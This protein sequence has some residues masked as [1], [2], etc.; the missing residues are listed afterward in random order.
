MLCACLLALCVALGAFAALVRPSGAARAGER[1]AFTQR[2]DPTYSIVKGFSLRDPFTGRTFRLAAGLELLFAENNAG[3]HA[4]CIQLGQMICDTGDAPRRAYSL[5]DGMFSRLPAQAKENIALAAL[6]GYPNRSAAE[7][8]A[9]A[10][11]AHVATQLLLW[12]AALGYRDAAYLRTDSRIAD[13]YFTGGAHADVRA[14]YEAIALRIQE[15]LRTPSFLTHESLLLALTYDPA[16]GLYTQRFTDT[17]GSNADLAV[18]GGGVT[19]ER[20]GDDYI[21]SSETLPLR[22]RSL[23]I[24]RTDIPPAR[25]GDLGPL[26]IWVDPDCGP[27][28]QFL[29][30]GVA[31]RE[32]CWRA[33]LPPGEGETTTLPET[34]TVTEPCPTTTDPCTTTDHYTTTTDPCATTENITT[35]AESTT[36]CTTTTAIITTSCTTSKETT[37]RQTTT[38][39]TTRTTHSRTTRPRPTTERQTTERRTFTRPTKPSTEKCTTLPTSAPTTTTRPTTQPTTR[40]TTTCP[41]STTVVTPPRTGDTQAAPVLIFAMCMGSLGLWLAHR[42]REG[43]V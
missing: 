23:T 22:E 17:S 11:T 12:E 26:L 29:F 27:D 6:F 25:I 7:L 14:V 38:A 28:N 5:Y 40:P 13:A 8:G 39:R 42:R 31:P 35:T 33:C 20:D 2:W 36:I 1:A 15:F 24:A 21:F 19:I 9:G 41:A 16:S 3:V 10:T 30:S 32:R 37:T 43:N 18:T 4:Y 34:T